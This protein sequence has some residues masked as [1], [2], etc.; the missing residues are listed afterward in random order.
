[1]TAGWQWVR[2]GEAADPI[3]RPEE[4][5]PGLSYRQIGVRL[6]GEGAYEREPVDGS[7][8]KYKAL[9]RVQFGDIIVNKIWARHGSVSVVLDSLEGCHCSGE[10]PL[11][12][13][14]P[15]KLKPGWFYWITKN[16]W[17]WQSW[18]PPFTV[19]SVG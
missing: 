2:I 11:F 10:F 3:N 19:L 12:K 16:P 5:I 18:T 17:F 1:V 14:R 6:W 15:D 9:N 8:I 13:P 7:S 4:P